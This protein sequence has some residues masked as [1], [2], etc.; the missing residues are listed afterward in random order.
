MSEQQV[1]VLDASSIIPSYVKTLPFNLRFGWLSAFN[2]ASDL[3]GIDRGVLI[4]N[5]WVLKKIEE[6]KNEP[7]PLDD[8][9]EEV[10]E[11]ILEMNGIKEPSLEKL[12][13]IP[14]EFVSMSLEPK[15]G[16]FITYSEDGEI[17]IEAVI[18]DDNYNDLGMR[19]SKNALKGMADVINKEGIALPDIEHQAYAQI[20]NEAATA[21]EVKEKLKSKK[22]MLKK[23]KAFYENGVL[24]VRAWLNKKYKKYAELYSK[25]SIEAFSP[26][27]YHNGDTYEMAEPLSFTF[28]NTPRLKNARVL[29][30]M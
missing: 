9:S 5:E 14:E 12:A 3:Y 18:A 29:S 20:L 13:E 26:S 17:I 6:M 4:A 16:E 15:Q 21:E 8:K 22:G 27:Q 28:T 11:A 7:V 19:F 25:I 2:T 1:T 24:I 23:I 10:K 30:V